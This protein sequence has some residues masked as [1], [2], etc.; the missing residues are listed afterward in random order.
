LAGNTDIE[1]SVQ[2]LDK[3]TQEE[4]RMASA[5]LLKVTHGV[6]GKVDDVHGDVQDVGSKVQNVDGRVQDVQDDVQD[7]GNK[8]QDVDNRVQDIGSDVKN[9]SNEVREVNRSSSL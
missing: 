5:E 7:V 3:L 6:D 4:A 2:R 8:V 9:I 1:D